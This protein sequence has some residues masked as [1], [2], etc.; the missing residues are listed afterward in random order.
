M[1]MA[2]ALEFGSN[3]FRTSKT[4]QANQYDKVGQLLGAIMCSQNVASAFPNDQAE[5]REKIYAPG[6]AGALSKPRSVLVLGA[7]N[8]MTMSIIHAPQ[9]KDKN[10]PPPDSNSLVRLTDAHLAL[11]FV[12]SDSGLEDKFRGNPQI[13][14]HYLKLLALVLEVGD[15]YSVVDKAAA[16]A[17]QG[18]TL[19]VYG[20]ANTQLNIMLETCDHLMSSLREA[21]STLARVAELRFEE[22]VFQNNATVKRNTWILFYRSIHSTLARIDKTLATISQENALIKIQANSL[23]LYEMFQQASKDTTEF[24]DAASD[25]A[26]HMS[27]VLGIT[28]APPQKQQVVHLPDINE[29]KSLC[30]GTDPRLLSSGKKKK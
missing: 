10:A 15:L 7:K 27:H 24:L 25:F 23:T 17:S 12:G 11:M 4:R 14:R 16:C 9:I 26:D 20:L 28:Y 13:A 30:N 19:L 22:L 2:D 29:L 18:G 21:C 3:V 8:E 5:I 1:L 6:E